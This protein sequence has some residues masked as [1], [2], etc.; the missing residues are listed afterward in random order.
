MRSPSG[1]P[2]PPKTHTGRSRRGSRPPPQLTCTDSSGQA[3]HVRQPTRLMPPVPEKGRCSAICQ[4]RFPPPLPAPRS[5]PALPGLPRGKGEPQPL[6]SRE[7]DEPKAAG[8]AASSPRQHRQGAE[9]DSPLSLIQRGDSALPSPECLQSWPE[10]KG[11][12]SP[13]P[14]GTHPRAPS[15]HQLPQLLGTAEPG[16]IKPPDR[17]PP[18]QVPPSHQLGY[19]RLR[20]HR[21]GYYQ[22]R[23][24]RAT[25]LGTT[26]S[27]TTGSGTTKPLGHVPPH[28]VPP[29][30]V[31]PSHWVGYHWVGHHRAGSHRVAGLG[32]G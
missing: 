23:Y 16:T 19:H 17:V 12:P 5:P 10:P 18:G 26:S 29:G 30:R 4:R 25:G 27:G 32:A 9:G 13:A 2:P 8:A 21:L 20:Y 28:Q 15:L 22:V 24:H 7:A 1:R 14:P 31:L 6:C 11:V 3:S